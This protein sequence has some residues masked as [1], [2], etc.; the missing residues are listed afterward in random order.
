MTPFEAK[1]ACDAPRGNY[2]ERVTH[3]LPVGGMRD[4]RQS[5]YSDDVPLTQ[6]K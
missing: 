5:A 3:E 4:N 2:H 1:V 6:R